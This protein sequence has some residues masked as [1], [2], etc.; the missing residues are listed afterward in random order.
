MMKFKPAVFAVADTYHIMVPVS[1]KSLMWVT[2]GDKRYCDE[3][4][5]ILRSETAIHR[6]IVPAKELNEAGEYTVFERDVINRKPY[7]PEFE[8]E[9]ATKFSFRAVPEGDN[10]RAFYLSD[11]H[12]MIDL[13][14]AAAKAYGEI[15]FLIMNGDIPDHSGNVENFDTIYAIA[16]ALTGGEIPI[17]F[18][19]GNHDMRG[20]CAECIAD[21]TPN[22]NGKTYYTFKIG[23]I[24]GVILDCAEDKD[25]TNPEYGGTICCRNF[26]L[27]QT[28]FLKQLIT[29]NK[30][31]YGA[32]DVKLKLVLS[33]HPFCYSIG[34]KFTIETDIYTEWCTLLREYIKPDLMISGHLHCSDIFKVGEKLDNFGQPCTA[35]VGGYPK[36]KENKYE[37]FGVEWKNGEAEITF[38]DSNGTVFRQEKI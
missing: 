3:S 31:E 2:I 37:A 9:V 33:H 20:L 13:P 11:T 1:K 6:I 24:W 34:D 32:D 10:V 28:D 15:D 8:E 4:N 18:A 35:V 36:S 17:V 38:V 7:F 14:I 22:H 16:D 23:S 27:S 21:Y 26:R 29:D 5:G 12:N 19:R 30:I 25:D